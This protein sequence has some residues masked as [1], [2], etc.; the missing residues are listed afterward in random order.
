M[1][2]PVEY[3]DIRDES[4]PQRD[5]SFKRVKRYTFWLGK[6]GPFVERVDLEGFSEFEIQQRVAKVRQH[7]EELHR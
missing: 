4:T 6:F 3:T 1:D 5:G 2:L 7:V